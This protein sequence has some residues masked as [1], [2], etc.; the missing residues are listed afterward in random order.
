M[1]YL[2]ILIGGDGDEFCFFE[3]ERTEGTPAQ[4]DDRIRPGD[5]E[6]RLVLVHRIEYGLAKQQ[7]TR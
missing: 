3:N 4:I 5:V 2:F 1:S 6:S 7:A